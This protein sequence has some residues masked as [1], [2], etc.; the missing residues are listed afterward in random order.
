MHHLLMISLSRTRLASLI[1]LLP[2][3]VS[4][5]Q[6]TPVS[7]SFSHAPGY[8]DSGSE[9]TNSVT[10][11]SAWANPPVTIT[12]TDVAE[13]VGWLNVDPTVTFTFATPVTIRSVTT[14]LADSDGSAGVG[15]PSSVT[16]STPGGFSQNFLV[17]NPPGN[18]STVAFTFTGFE[19]TTDTF[20]VQ[21]NRA[22]QRTMASEMQFF[23]TASI[24]EPSSAA[25]LFG[26]LGLAGATGGRRRPRRR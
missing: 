9:L 13:L 20:A 8:A 6:L 10:F 22:H 21:L 11:S 5:A 1:A 3:A 14:W 17:S 18:G 26:A 12:L 23:D 24:P 19:V 15:V 2:A 7:Y 4:A 16:L 25:F